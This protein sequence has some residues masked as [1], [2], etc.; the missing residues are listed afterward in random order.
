MICMESYG[1]CMDLYR[2]VKTWV[3]KTLVC[4]I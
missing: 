3:D 4:I 1:I 2:F